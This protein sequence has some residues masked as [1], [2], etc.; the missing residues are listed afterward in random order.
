M[1]FENRTWHASGI[2]PSGRPRIALMLQYGYR[3]LQ[4]VDDPAT[5]LLVDPALSP[6]EQQLVG[7][8]DRNPDGSLAKGAG[9]ALLRSW[10]HSTE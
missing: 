4:P 6:S 2:N 1:L 5:D 10:W 3:W 8:P 9:A 7:M